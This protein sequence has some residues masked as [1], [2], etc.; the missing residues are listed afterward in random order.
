ML[1][2][3]GLALVVIGG[4]LLGYQVLA[5]GVVAERP[6]GGRRPLPAPELAETAAVTFGLI[7][8][9]VSRPRGGGAGAET[10]HPRH[11]SP[12]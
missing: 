8:L 6:V 7:L 11:I 4:L 12:A 2:L 10:V 5:L 3:I 1:R 9:A